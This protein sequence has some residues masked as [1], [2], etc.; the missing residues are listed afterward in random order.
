MPCGAPGIHL[1]RGA[2][3]D[4]GREQGRGADRHD[5]IVV[6]VEDERRHVELLEIFGEIRLGE[7]LD[8]IDRRL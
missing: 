1:Q 3:D 2:L 7:G 6:A 5:L 8:A 4:L